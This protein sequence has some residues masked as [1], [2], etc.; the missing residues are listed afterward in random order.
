V[1]QFENRAAYPDVNAGV[2][3]EREL[4]DMAWMG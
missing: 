3:P 2:L 1:R 4:E